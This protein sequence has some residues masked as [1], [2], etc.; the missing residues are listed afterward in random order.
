[1]EA[2]NAD[3]PIVATNVGDNGQLVQNEKNGFLSK[4][5]D[6]KGISSLLARLV[7][8]EEL[9]LNMGKQSKLFLFTNYSVEK[10]R[11]LYF[12][13]LSPLNKFRI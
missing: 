7:N 2:M 3:L 12:A 1:M 13:V 9:R 8:D 4:E 11:E 6:W 10:F 5:K